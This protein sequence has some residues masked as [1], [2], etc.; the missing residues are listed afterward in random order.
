MADAVA[1]EPVSQVEFPANRE[2]NREFHQNPPAAAWITAGISPIIRP[3]SIRFH[4]DRNREFWEREQGKLFSE[5]G[6]SPVDSGTQLYA[7]AV[8]LTLIRLIG[9]RLGCDEVRDF[10]LASQLEAENRLLL[11]T[12][13]V[14]NTFVLA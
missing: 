11:Q 7:A 2:I 12:I 10:G 14:R 1:V 13:G 3:L 5:Q 8:G 6:I 9:F 4:A